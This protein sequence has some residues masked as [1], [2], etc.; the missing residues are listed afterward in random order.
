MGRWLYENHVTAKSLFDQASDVLGYDLAELCLK[1]PDD[2]LNATEFG[3]PALFTVGMAAARVLGEELR[4]GPPD[5][6]EDCIP[7]LRDDIPVG[8][9]R[10]PFTGMSV[11]AG[12]LAVEEC[13][14]ACTCESAEKLPLLVRLRVL[15]EAD[16]VWDPIRSYQDGVRRDPTVT[17]QLQIEVAFEDG[18][19]ADARGV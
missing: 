12:C 11:L 1:G 7:G 16:L 4:V 8:T 15:S 3:Q 19:V 2:R 5:T 17:Q 18:E 6:R 13:R 9:R 10:E 14:R